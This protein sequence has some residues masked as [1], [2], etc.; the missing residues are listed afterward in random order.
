MN[1]TSTFLWAATAAAVCVFLAD[2]RPAPAADDGRNIRTGRTIPDEGYCDQPYIV[3]TKDGN[4]LCT[5]TTGRGQEGQKGQHVVATISSD[6]GKTWSPL[7][8]IEPAD[9]PEAS[10][11]VPLVVPGGRVYAFY[12]YNGDRVSTMPGSSKPIRADMLGWFVYKYSDDHGRTWSHERHRLPMRLT[13]CDRTNQWQGKVQVFW[14]IDKPKIAGGNVY[15]AFTKLGRYMLDDGE[16]W[17][18]RSDNLLTE[19]DAS[20]LRWQLLPEGEHGIRAA[21]FGSVQEEH[22]LV[23]LGDNQLYCIYRTTTGYPCHSYSRD[24]GRT[25]SVPEQVTYEPGGRKLK[26]PRACPK[27]WRTADGRFLLWYHNHSGR[28][29]E[30]RNPAWIAG[31]TLRDGKMYWSQP[32]ILLYD[33]T[34]SIRMSYPDLVEQDGR[35]W[36]T[37]TQKTTARVHEIDK[38]LLEGLWNQGRDK[39]VARRGLTLDLDREQ[40]R[41]GNAKLPEKLDLRQ[42]GGLTLD[43]WLKLDDLA[44]GQVI[45]DNR[46]AAGSGFALT[47]AADGA[48]RIELTSDKVKASWDSDPGVLRRGKLHHVV[49]TV[50]AGPR[51]ITFAIDGVL[52]D[53]GAARQ[54]GWG[55]YDG[56]LTELAGSGRLQ[57]APQ[58]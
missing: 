5:L 38:T 31:G 45:L 9:G 46:D 23:P 57:L 11:V 29:F 43:A 52:C 26:N 47:T 14:G 6:Q 48:L 25:W 58:R 19:P 36:V 13:A 35:Y 4:W 56:E 40:I 53:G 44:A 12:D 1:N 16:G 50:D 39:T 49:C 18:Y 22:N 51:I 3:V 15:F 24:G 33:P 37:E 32:E 7:V 21:A 8:D 54:F 20:K 28:T 10:W 34:P 55:R 17:L 41:A 2:S 27:L 42:T 30:S